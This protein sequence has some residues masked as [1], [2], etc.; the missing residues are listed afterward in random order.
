MKLEANGG[1]EYDIVL[2]SDYVLSIARKE[3]LLLA[4]DKSKLAN[5]GNLN[6]RTSASITIRTAPTPSP[7]RSA[8]P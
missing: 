7:T 2:A 8:R 1:S 6:P 5:Y 4:L 3:G